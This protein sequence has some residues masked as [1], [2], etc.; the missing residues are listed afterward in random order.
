MGNMKRYSPTLLEKTIREK[1][2]AFEEVVGKL[3]QVEFKLEHVFGNRKY[4]RHIF[5]PAGHA[6]SGE[7]HK[8]SCINYIPVGRV[9][10]AS[11]DGTDAIVAPCSWESGPGVK[12]VGVTLEDTIWITIHDN[13]EGITDLKEIREYLTVPNYT[14]F[15]IQN[16]YVKLEGKDE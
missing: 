14:A 6:F 9:L 7:I 11:K 1:L 8:H 13:P 16:E 15:P 2:Y 10:V 5:I 3:P 4:A 12:R